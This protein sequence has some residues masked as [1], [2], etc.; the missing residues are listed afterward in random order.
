MASEGNF[1]VRQYC[2]KQQQHECRTHILIHKQ[3]VETEYPGNGTSLL[4]SP[5]PP[6]WHTVSNKATPLNP[7]QTDPLCPSIQ[8]CELLTRG[9]LIQTTTTA[10]LNERITNFH[11]ILEQLHRHDLWG[12]REGSWLSTLKMLTQPFTPACHPTFISP[13]I[14][15][16][17]SPHISCTFIYL[18][19]TSK[20]FW[21]HAAHCFRKLVIHSMVVS[22][23]VHASECFLVKMFGKD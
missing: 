6:Q 12:R 13:P 20:A 9:F 1:V 5:S 15:L 7:S 16:Y 11:L 19:W 23:R 2:S 18:A 22:V 10:I 14:V 3:E 17:L 21:K 4:K 8:I